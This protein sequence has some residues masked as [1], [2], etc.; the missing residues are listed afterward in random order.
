MHESKLNNF[1]V[2]L[3]EP[4]GIGF[5]EEKPEAMMYRNL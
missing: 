5:I 3:A 1:M 4:I 2:Y